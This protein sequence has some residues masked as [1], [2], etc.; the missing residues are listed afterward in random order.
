MLCCFVPCLDAH[1]VAFLPLDP[2]V[3]PPPKNGATDSCA[4]PRDPTRPDVRV[5]DTSAKS[6][7]QQQHLHLAS[8]STR[9][10][11]LIPKFTSILRHLNPFSNS[12]LSSVTEHFHLEMRWEK[13]TR[14]IIRVKLKFL[15][16]HGGIIAQIPP[17]SLGSLPNP[18]FLVTI[19]E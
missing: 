8:S 15:K 3:I 7:A 19:F 1:S 10:L 11:L 6:K 2:L 18:S 14:E 4:F 13:G 9:S 12:F 16:R 17:S 5:R